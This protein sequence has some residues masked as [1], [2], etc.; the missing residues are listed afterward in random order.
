MQEIGNEIKSVLRDIFYTILLCGGAA[1]IA[2]MAKY[3]ALHWRVEPF[4]ASK[5]LIG[6]LLAT[7]Q[8]SI[9]GL[10]VRGLGYPYAFCMGVVGGAIFIGLQWL[11]DTFKRLV[12]QRLK[13]DVKE[14]DK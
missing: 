10:L 6:I 5:L 13:I 2:S 7:V 14:E 11:Q 1:L 3:F 4:M 8:G 9:L 12:Y